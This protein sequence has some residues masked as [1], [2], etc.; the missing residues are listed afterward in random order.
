M[1]SDSKQ[2]KQ[3]VNLSPKAMVDSIAEWPLGRV[4]EALRRRETES[5]Y[6]AEECHV[7]GRYSVRMLIPSIDELASRYG[8]SRAKM[9]RWVSYHAVALLREDTTVGKLSTLCAT[10]R[11][12]ALESADVDALSAMSGATPYMPLNITDG[13]ASLYLYEPWVKSE[14]H[15]KA[16]VCGMPA[17]LLAQ[18]FFMQSILSIDLSGFSGVLR[19]FEAE[20]RRWRFWMGQRVGMV[21]EIADGEYFHTG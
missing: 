4:V 20:L 13:W 17:F 3:G 1:T 14:L 12:A 2:D 15:E 7:S 8:V 9:S 6:R 11:R 5:G 16:L 19:L 21:T 10:I 18:V